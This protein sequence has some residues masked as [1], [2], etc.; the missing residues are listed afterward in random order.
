MPAMEPSPPLPARLSVSIVLHD[1]AL[2]I[3]QRVLQGL[4]RAAVRAGEAG[5]VSRVRVLVLDNSP[6]TAYRGRAAALVD[7]CP[8]NGFYRADYRELADNRGFGAAHNAALRELDSDFH[9]VLNPDA[10]L[11]ETALAAG[12]G[13]LQDSPGTVLVSPRVLGPG[14]SQEFLCK[15]YPSVLV[16]LV[17]AFAPGPVRPLFRERLDRY[18]MRDACSGDQPAEVEL[19]SGCF[20]LVRTDDL[21]S[22]GGFDEGYFLYFEDFDLSLRLAARGR[23]VFDPAVEILHH[24]GYAARKGLRHLR[25]FIRSGVTFFHRH[26]WRWI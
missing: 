1:N 26:G 20:M 23:L 14:G 3:L 25:Y 19:A 6:D 24:G 12:V 9:L 2:D 18:E 11:A 15:R 5:R 10:E 22:V 8:R 13:R 7:A 17:R 21:R 4:H 16:L